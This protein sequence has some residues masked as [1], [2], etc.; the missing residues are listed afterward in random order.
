VVNAFRT[1]FKTDVKQIPGAESKL[2]CIDE[3]SFLLIKSWPVKIETANATVARPKYPTAVVSPVARVVHSTGSFG[4]GQITA[5]ALRPAP[6]AGTSSLFGSRPADQV[7][8][9][10]FGFGSP[11]AAAAPPPQSSHPFGG[12]RPT[13]APTITATRSAGLFG[14]SGV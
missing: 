5:Q 14:L 10:V 12:G 2:D 9:S 7:L 13:V 1:E 8:R 3:L 11:Q 4:G 6:T